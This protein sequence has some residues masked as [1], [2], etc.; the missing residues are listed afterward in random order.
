MAY[1]QRIPLQAD[2]QLSASIIFD[3]RS[4]IAWLFDPLI[5]ARDRS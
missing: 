3:R 1:G 5:S 2:M 4:F